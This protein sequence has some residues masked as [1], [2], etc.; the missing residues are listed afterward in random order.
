MNN[1][2][3][4]NDVEDFD[5]ITLPMSLIINDEFKHISAEAKIMYGL[6]KS[7]L[8]LSIRNEWFDNEGKAYLIFTIEEICLML[9]VSKKTGIKIL[10]E[11]EKNDFLEK[12]RRGLGL[13]N[14]IYMKKIDFEK[15]KREYKKN[16]H[17]FWKVRK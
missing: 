9:N 11:L 16:K 8:K 6:L 12:K 17:L 1:Y 14:Y 7:R 10:N 5:F 13:P 4:R 2:F 15:V 3:F